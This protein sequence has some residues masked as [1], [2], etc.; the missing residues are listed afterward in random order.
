MSAAL[1]MANVKARGIMFNMVAPL[2]SVGLTN[3][4]DQS[5]V[6]SIVGKFRSRATQNRTTAHTHNAS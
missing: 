2:K 5:K 4:K 6:K 1:G 3:T